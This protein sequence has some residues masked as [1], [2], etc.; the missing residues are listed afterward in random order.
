MISKTGIKYTAALAAVAILST[1]AQAQLRQLEISGKS[2]LAGYGIKYDGGSDSA[3][4][5]DVDLDFKMQFSQDV[6][7]RI[8]LEVDNAQAGDSLNGLAGGSPNRFSIG[9]DQAYF[10]MND[11]LFRNFALSLGKQ[12]LNISLRDNGTYNVF[13]DP[14]GV[15]G[16]YS[17]RDLDLKAYFLKYN[18]DSDLSATSTNDQDEELFGITG[19]YWL[20]DDSLV[21][22]YLNYA[23]VSDSAAASFNAIQYGIGLDYFIGESLEVYGEIAG[24]SLDASA[25]GVGAGPDGSAFQLTLGGEYAFTDFDM[26]PT[27]GLEYYLQSG[28]DGADS[29]WVAV[30]GAAGAAADT[31]TLYAES[32]G[33]ANAANDI[34]F[35]TGSVVSY[36]DSAGTSGGY[37]VIRLNGAL[38]P[39]KATKVGLGIHFLSG[40]DDGADD[41]GTEFDLYGSWKYSQDVSFKAGLFYF[42]A[43]AA[44]AEVTGLSVASALKF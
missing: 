27:L 43:D 9:V 4:K 19:E 34:S 20:N 8:D 33:I 17:T 3:F 26:K 21:L 7:A 35:G 25:T 39:S 1:S 15:V 32:N 11:F 10:K 44:D 2:S 23:S 30:G 40:E 14:V 31:A 41:I 16:T 28:A 5:M 42:D 38:S 36:G 29:A 6:S 12:D 18:D 37:S 22:G 13:G 24:E